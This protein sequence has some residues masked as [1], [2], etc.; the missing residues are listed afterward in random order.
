MWQPPSRLTTES[1]RRALALATEFTYQER[2][3]ISEQIQR[4]QTGNPSQRERRRN[5]G[6]RPAC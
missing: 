2:P 4:S 1:A 5:R 3:K 6:G